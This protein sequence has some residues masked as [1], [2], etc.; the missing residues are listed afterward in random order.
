MLLKEHTLR[1]DR[2]FA[3][4]IGNVS[5][6]AAENYILEPRLKLELTSTELK[7][8]WFYTLSY[9]RDQF[10]KVLYLGESTHFFY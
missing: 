8:Q 10:L 6:E 9:K 4:S 7:T 1:S 2:C 3:S 5:K